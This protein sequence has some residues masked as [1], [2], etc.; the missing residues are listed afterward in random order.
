M[1]RGCEEGEGYGKGWAGGKSSRFPRQELSRAGKQ[2]RQVG[3]EMETRQFGG[4][5]GK[6]CKALLSAGWKSAAEPL[7]ALAHTHKLS[8]LCTH[9]HLR[10]AGKCCS[11]QIDAAALQAVCLPRGHKAWGIDTGGR[12]QQTSCV[13]PLRPILCAEGSIPW[14]LV[15]HS[16]RKWKISLCETGSI[17]AHTKETVEFISLVDCYSCIRSVRFS[18]PPSPSQSA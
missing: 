5:R 2:K 7:L 9:F 11:E 4:R 13:L 8:W 17:P 6:W 18:P 3:S 14:A 16:E 12:G 15:L 10:R 1:A